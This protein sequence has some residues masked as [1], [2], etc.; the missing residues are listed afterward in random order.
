MLV[1]Q[2]AAQGKGGEIFVLDMGRPI[3]IV[4]LAR[5]MIELSGF[6]PDEDIR[7][8]FTGVRPGEKLFEEL[9]QNGE[10]FAP[11]THSKIFRFVSQPADLAC[12]QKTLHIL[13]AHLDHAGA[14]ELKR[15]LRLAVPEYAP[16][17]RSYKP[18]F[19]LPAELELSQP[20]VAA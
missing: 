7:I 10:D 15:L 20:H 18:R 6:K 4:D 9:R 1:L 8:E 2:S 13:R 17:L 11:T 14:E 12:I 16:D 5:Q 3:R 19:A